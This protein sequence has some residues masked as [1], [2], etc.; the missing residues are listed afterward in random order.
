MGDE[1]KRRPAGLAVSTKVEN[2][3]YVDP[4][5][6]AGDDV[7]ALHPPVDEDGLPLDSTVNISEKDLEEAEEA[8]GE[9]DED[10]R[11]YRDVSLKGALLSPDGTQPEVE[12]LGDKIKDLGDKIRPKDAPLAAAPPLSGR[13]RRFRS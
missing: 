10:A 3:W 1:K 5:I 13:R 12:T 9:A 2:A 11:H 7:D 6:L 8:L 4:N